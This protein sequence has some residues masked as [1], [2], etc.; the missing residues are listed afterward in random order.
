MSLGDLPEPNQCKDQLCSI[1]HSDLVTQTICGDCASA[2]FGPIHTIVP[3]LGKEGE[4]SYV[5]G[6]NIKGSLS[7]D[8]YENLGETRSFVRQLST[9][10]MS[11]AG[12]DDGHIVGEQAYNPRGKPTSTHRREFR[13]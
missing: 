9:V 4:P 5:F 6:T 13:G 2:S 7:N 12:F 8:G 3:S 1:N 10:S 11:D